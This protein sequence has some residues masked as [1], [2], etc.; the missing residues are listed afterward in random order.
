MQIKITVAAVIGALVTMPSFATDPTPAERKTVTSKNYVDTQVATRQP[1]IP[2]TGTNSAT[3]GTT[4]VMYTGTAGTIGE[5]QL[6]SGSAN[7]NAG[8]D[9][10]K[11]VTADAL[12]Y[13]AN[14]LPTIETSKLTCANQ[15]CTLWT[16]D[17]QTVYGSNS[18]NNGGN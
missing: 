6:Y 7:Y 14:H 5:R 8:T 15:D 11:L 16:I 3:P 9:A 1:K 2:V 13:R 12:D 4:V 18:G 17:D 10:N